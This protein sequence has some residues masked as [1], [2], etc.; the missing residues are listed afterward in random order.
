MN[1]QEVINSIIKDAEGV[2]HQN[3]KLNGVKQRTEMAIRK[4]FGDK[5][6]Y[7][8]NLKKIRF[9][10][11]MFTTSTPPSYFERYFASGVEDL[12]TLLRTMLE[13]V[14]LGDMAS[15]PLPPQS[16]NLKLNQS[17]DVFI[18]HGHN[19]AMKQGVARAVEKLGLNAVILHEQASKGRTIIEKFDAHTDV[20]FAIILLSADDL[21]YSKAESPNMAKLRARQNVVFEM[22]FFIGKLGRERVLSLYETFENFDLPSDYSGVVLTPYDSNGAWQYILIRELKAIGIS[23]DANALV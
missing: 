8:D 17:K 7:L 1:A 11:A 2:T 23:V 16:V 3:G 12:T 6:H 22:G 20:A 10:P 14:Q 19:E 21:A 13:D 9:E 15:A 4:A 18:V 5:S